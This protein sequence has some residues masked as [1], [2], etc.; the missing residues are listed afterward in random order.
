M[1]SVVDH[2]AG[3]S[4]VSQKSAGKLLAFAA[5]L[6]GA[7][8]GREAGTRKLGPAGV[9]SMLMG[10]KGAVA[11]AL[12]GAG[13][14][15]IFGGGGADWARTTAAR[16]GV[17]L[18]HER[19]GQEV[20]YRTATPEGKPAGRRIGGPLLLLA[21]LAVLAALFFGALGRRRAPD[22]SKAVPHAEAPRAPTEQ[23]P[24]V[25]PPPTV[26]GPAAPAPP[27]IGGGP[28]AAVSELN[29]FFTDTSEA[30][31]KRI[32]LEGLT[33]EHDSDRL[34]AT[35]TKSL[36]GVATALKEHPSAKVRID[37]FTDDT[38]NPDY[39]KKLSANRANAVRDALV[40]QGVDAQR[41]T[42]IGNGAANPIAPNDTEEGR[43]AN[44][45][46]DLVMLSR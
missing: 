12:G 27:A 7:V 34:T 28:S 3:S 4:G 37:G 9:A 15:S 14:A 2:V 13:L 1:S 19:A 8:V 38:G 24:A 11:S 23:A 45:R 17:Q 39:N 25:P 26:Q 33:F 10:Q 16:A 32:P 29:Q 35:A 31:P 20:R 41:I 44:R 18:P 6:M 46:I 42:V 21:A 36:E 30:T 22:L 43:A 40:R 5:P